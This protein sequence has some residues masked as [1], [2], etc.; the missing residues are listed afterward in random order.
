MIIKIIQAQFERGE[1]GIFASEQE[2]DDLL[3]FSNQNFNNSSTLSPLNPA[4]AASGNPASFI[5]S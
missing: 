5:G 1:S 3:P 4:K 2:A